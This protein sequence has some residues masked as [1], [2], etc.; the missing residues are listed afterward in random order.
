M[1]RNQNGVI[2]KVLMNSNEYEGDYRR[3]GTN[4]KVNRII[5]INL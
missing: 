1:G 2:W 4:M 5:K 3:I